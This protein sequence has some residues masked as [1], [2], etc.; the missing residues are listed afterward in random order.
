MFLSAT[1]TAVDSTPATRTDPLELLLEDREW[2]TA[3]FAAIMKASGFRDRVIIETLADPPHRRVR[4]VRHG[5]PG[6]RSL[7]GTPVTRVA[8]RVRSPPGRSC[9][10]W[11]ARSPVGGLRARD[12][13]IDAR[14]SR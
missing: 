1:A 10:S 9:P 2:V 13:R 14:D 4:W 3:Q 6:W 7:G 5:H 8:S 11:C 12:E